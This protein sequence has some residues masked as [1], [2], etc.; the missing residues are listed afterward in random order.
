MNEHVET[1]LFVLDTAC[2][3]QQLVHNCPALVD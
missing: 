1:E 2:F 3:A